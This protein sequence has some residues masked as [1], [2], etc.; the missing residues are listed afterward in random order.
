MTTEKE[1]SI[2]GSQC[3]NNNNNP[4]KELVGTKTQQKKDAFC[5]FRILIRGFRNNYEAALRRALCKTADRL[6]P[7]PTLY[8][9]HQSDDNSVQSSSFWLNY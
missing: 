7:T 8:Y 6:Q 4:S 2:D 1:K 9:T 5:C 3:D